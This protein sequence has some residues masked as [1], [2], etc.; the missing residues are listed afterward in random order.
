MA[1][2]YYEVLSVKKTATKDEIKSAFRKLARQYHPDVNKAPDAAEKFKE[3]NEA[4]EVLSDDNKRA[5]YDRFGPAGVQG[6]GGGYGAGG[7]FTSVDFEDMFAEIFSTFGGG[8]TSTRRA[9]PRQG[10][11]IR[12]DVTLD[13]IEAAL[14][15]TQE[16]EYQRLEA[17][18]VCHGS[19]AEAGT[20]PTTCPECNGQGQTRRVAQTFMGAVVT[21]T[22]CPRC[23]GRGTIITNPCRN[24]D[25]SGRKRKKVKLSLNIPAG[26]AEGIR[27]QQRGDGDVGE[28]GA[29]SGDLYIV[30][31]VKD[32]EVFKRRDNDIILDW[33][34]NLAQAA[35][36]DKITVPTIEGEVE[37]PIPAGTQTGKVFRVRGK[38][39]PR[40]RTDG[41]SAGRGDQ[42]VYINVAVPTKLTPRQKELFEQLAET[43]GKDLQQQ[44]GRGFF[45]RV[46]DFINGSGESGN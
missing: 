26:V 37:L 45:E 31:H 33:S 34:I 36:G 38:G 1:R 43:F 18:E 3:I 30:V 28:L 20:S 44:Q 4:Y 40:L 42:L 6:S 19:G 27:I 25:G 8:R 5:R 15:T 16:I 12:L 13:F 29:P 22:D 23:G 10:G 46:M 11:D 21:M 9:G 14:G 17:C 41:S 32:H 35:L 2:D 39:V 24:C 7:G